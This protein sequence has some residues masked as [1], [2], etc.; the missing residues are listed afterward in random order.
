MNNVNAVQSQHVAPFFFV[1]TSSA[2]LAISY[3]VHHYRRSSDFGSSPHQMEWNNCAAAGKSRHQAVPDS[4]GNTA[5]RWGRGHLGRTFTRE[6]SQGFENGTS[7]MPRHV[8]ALPAPQENPTLFAALPRGHVSCAFDV[9]GTSVCDVNVSEEC[10][11]EDAVGDAK[12]KSCFLRMGE[13]RW[14]SLARYSRNMYTALHRF[15]LVDTA[16]DPELLFSPAKKN[17]L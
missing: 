2:G 10:L 12:L 17:N 3:C 13:L 16:V 4:G 1:N 14:C 5:N 9:C 11:D 6:R 8:F 15:L 7:A